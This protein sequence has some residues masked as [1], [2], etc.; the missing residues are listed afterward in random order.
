LIT[1]PQPKRGSS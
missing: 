1:L